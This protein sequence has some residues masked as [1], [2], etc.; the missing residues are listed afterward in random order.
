MTEALTWMA[1]NPDRLMMSGGLLI[2]VAAVGLAV[3]Y[4][5]DKRRR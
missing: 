1:A 4:W 2:A 5:I 3:E